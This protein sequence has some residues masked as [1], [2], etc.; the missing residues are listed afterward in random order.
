M[1]LTQ[2]CFMNWLIWS[3]LHFSKA[4]LFNL[5]RKSISSFDYSVPVFWSQA[6]QIVLWKQ[7][8]KIKI[9]HHDFRNLQLLDTHVVL[10][11]QELSFKKIRAKFIFVQTYRAK[12]TFLL[13]VK[14][15]KNSIFFVLLKWKSGQVEHTFWASSQ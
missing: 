4:I 5:L 10:T 7:S 1:Q 11:C 8:L 12:K 9:C 14:C 15:H 13:Q 3:S 2:V 6:K